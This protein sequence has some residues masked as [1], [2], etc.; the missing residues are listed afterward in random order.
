M[1]VVIAR[2]SEDTLCVLKTAT[3]A[4]DCHRFILHLDVYLSVSEDVNP[5][6]SQR[7]LH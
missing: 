7:V 3:D 5:S 4:V 2:P 6:E 1:R